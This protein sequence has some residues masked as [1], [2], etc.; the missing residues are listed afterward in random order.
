MKKLICATAL[1]LAMATNLHAANEQLPESIAGMMAMKFGRGVTNMV[2][3]VAEIPKQTI[4]M[5][6]DMGGVGYLVGPFSGVLMTGY[7]AIIGVT[8]TILFMVP[9][10]GYYDPML[11]PEF[12][13][14]GWDAAPKSSQLNLK[15]SNGGVVQ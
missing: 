1:F 8:E 12:V 9:A 2:T 7:R 13:W 10:P 5:G 14:V 4:I 3:A 6:R 15:T 11:E